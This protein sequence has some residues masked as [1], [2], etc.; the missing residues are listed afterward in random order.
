MSGRPA[1][2]LDRPTTHHR[3]ALSDDG[4]GAVLCRRLTVGQDCSSFFGEKTGIGGVLKKKWRFF[5]LLLVSCSPV[6]S[7]CWCACVAATSSSVV[8]NIVRQMAASPGISPQSSALLNVLEARW[9]PVE[10]AIHCLGD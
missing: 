3:C 1:D 8:I 9:I 5:F 10:L 4:V 6:T 2:D 7:D